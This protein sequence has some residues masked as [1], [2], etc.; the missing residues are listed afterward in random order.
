MDLGKNLSHTNIPISTL[1]IR[2][3]IVFLLPKIHH[4]M[5]VFY[6]FFGDV[7]KVFVS[8]FIDI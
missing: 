2:I 6:P 7:V 4:K 1:Y 3:F 5:F 8:L